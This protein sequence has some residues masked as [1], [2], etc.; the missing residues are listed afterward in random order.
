MNAA[1]SQPSVREMLHVVLR[2]KRAIITVFVLPVIV[3]MVLA[4]STQEL[5]QADRKVMIRAGRE[6]VPAL[7]RRPQCDFTPGT[8]QEA[9]DIE[10][11]ILPARMWHRGGSRRYG[12]HQPVISGASGYRAPAPYSSWLAN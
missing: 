8:M 4:Y 1:A 5:Y 6:Y 11:E 2:Y 10:V 3:A 7:D 12:R 9:I